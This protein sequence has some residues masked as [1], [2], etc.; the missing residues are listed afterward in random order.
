MFWITSFIILTSAVVVGLL[1][2]NESFVEPDPVEAVHSFEFVDITDGQGNTV[3]TSKSEML[4]V[5]LS[6]VN[7]IENSLLLNELGESDCIISNSIFL[8]SN[9]ASVTLLCPIQQ[10]GV[11]VNG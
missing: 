11:G 3:R 6:K 7:A 1:V 2:Y 9:T 5:I 8:D 4:S 10:V